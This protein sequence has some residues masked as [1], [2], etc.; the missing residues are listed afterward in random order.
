LHYNELFGPSPGGF[1]AASGPSQ[2]PRPAS[3]PCPPAG[4]APTTGRAQNASP[5]AVELVARFVRFGDDRA[6]SVGRVL[7]G[8]ARQFELLGVRTP[9]VRDYLLWE[10]RLLGSLYS[11]LVN[12]PVLS[13]SRIREL[14]L[15]YARAP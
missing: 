15:R 9:D 5:E 11:R 4:P 8:Y 13:P 7:T 12:L 3:R 1:E 10:Q 6:D 2:A 14:A